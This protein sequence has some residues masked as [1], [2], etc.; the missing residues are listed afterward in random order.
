MQRIDEHRLVYRVRDD[1][2][3]VI[4]VRGHYDA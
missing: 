1:L 4:Q 2:L 3:E